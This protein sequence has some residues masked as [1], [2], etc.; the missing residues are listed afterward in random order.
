V[1]ADTAA[2][3]RAAEADQGASPGTEP[4]ITLGLPPVCLQDHLA[5]RL[6]EGLASPAPI[7]QG[8]SGA[9]HGVCGEAPVGTRGENSAPAAQEPT[10]DE[11]PKEPEPTKSR[12]DGPIGQYRT[13]QDR[14]TGDYG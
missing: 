12:A 11:R 4:R 2:E 14:K 1:L 9:S 5:P 8:C 7:G 13:Q 6:H 3:P 10:R